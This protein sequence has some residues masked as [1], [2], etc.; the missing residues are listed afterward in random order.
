MA[1]KKQGSITTYRPGVVERVTDATVGAL[2]RQAH[3]AMGA[4][5][6]DAAREAN[7]VLAN[8]EEITGLKALENSAKRILYGNGT[9][10]DYATVGVAAIPA[11]GGVV[12]KRALKRT[13]NPA[14]SPS[15]TNRLYSEK[16]LAP[17]F[18]PNSPNLPKY[19]YR[20]VSSSA[21][22]DDIARSGYMRAAPGKKPNK[23]FTMSDAET[24]SAGNMGPKPVLRVRSDRIPEGSPVRRQDVEQWDN[25]SKAWK[26]VQRKAKGGAVKAAKPTK[27]RG[28]G[29]ARRGKTK[30]R[31][32]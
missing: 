9:T 30:G 7:R 15:V 13:L 23:Y 1:G 8:V 25:T 22:I 14:I 21:E 5:E 3:R 6:R 32:V 12:A 28:D 16:L 31:M 26:P 27:K 17:E 2:V 20:N 11:A 29:I 19:G 18:K 10:G 4:S 24:P